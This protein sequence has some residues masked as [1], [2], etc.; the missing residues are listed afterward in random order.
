[1]LQRVRQRLLDDAVRRETCGARDL[2]GPARPLDRDGEARATDALDECIEIAQAGLRAA[3]WRLG[4]VRAGERRLL[5]QHAEHAPHVGQRLASRARDL[6][7][8]LRRPRRV[9]GAC[10]GSGIGQRHHHLDV[11]RDHVVHLPR[12]AGA[13]RCRGERRLLVPLELQPLGAFGEPVELA[14]ER[15][16]DDAGQQRGEREA[17]EEHEG[18]DVVARRRPTHRRH[19]DTRLQDGRRRHDEHPVR[20]ERDGVQGDE[21]RR[22]GQSRSGH[23][24]LDERDRR[25]GEEDGHGCP[26]AEDER[27]DQGGDD[28]QAGTA[29]RLLN[30]PTRAQDE[31]T[32]GEDDVDGG[33]EAPVKGAQSLP[34]PPRPVELA[35]RGPRGRHVRPGASWPEPFRVQVT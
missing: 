2:E 7:H 34:D 30:H 22:V 10:P 19:D 3:R 26:A 27:E 9:L 28:P 14:A 18:L 24:P 6:P 35:V 32:G 25:D 33:G 31:Q 13:L 16:H 20:L 4:P 21:E 23:H 17:G 11:V 29:C 8:R 1:M 12:D 15:P 5:A